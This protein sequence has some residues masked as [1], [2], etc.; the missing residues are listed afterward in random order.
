MK[1]VAARIRRRRRRLLLSCIAFVLVASRCCVVS[2]EGGQGGGLGIE[3]RR[4]RPLHRLST[5]CHRIPSGSQE[6]VVNGEGENLK[7]RI[8]SSRSSGAV[9]I[10]VAQTARTGAVAERCHRYG[11]RRHCRRV[12][13]ENWPPLLALLGGRLL[14]GGGSSSK[15]TCGGDS[16]PSLFLKVAVSSAFETAAMLGVIVLSLE[17]AARFPRAFPDVGGGG[18]LPVTTWL[19][20]LAIIFASSFFGAVVDGGLGAATSQVL[21]PNEVPGEP[22]WYAKLKKPSW[23]PPGWLF[24]IMWLVVS[25]PT[26]LAAV[27]RLLKLC[28]KT[29]QY[30]AVGEGDETLAASA[31][32]SASSKLPLSTLT[33]YCG[34]LALGDA[35]NK[36]FFG[37]QCAG[38]GAAVITV[39]LGALL[40]SAF[41]FYAIDPAAGL[42]MLPTCGWVL[43][44]TALNWSIY[45]ANRE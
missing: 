32:A 34:H 33:L 39:F 18:G 42:L 20:L 45:L 4:R 14:R 44:A 38:R 3:H 15:T 16:E 36:V 23:N 13:K 41:A 29:S 24:P 27:S 11:C 2:A 1:L 35:W 9:A 21:T 43:V 8:V 40:A 17:V 7:G 5:T 6:I 31:A 10:S 12:E 30:S 19:G 22:N 26:Q 37:L 28:L 25:K